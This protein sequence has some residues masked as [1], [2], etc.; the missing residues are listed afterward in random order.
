MT[1]AITVLQSAITALE[2]VGLFDQRVAELY[3]AIKVLEEVSAK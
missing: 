2:R 1:Y 3:A